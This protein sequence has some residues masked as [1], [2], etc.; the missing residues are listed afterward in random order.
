MA[1]G[2][3]RPVRR[4][5]IRENLDPV[6]VRRHARVGQP[7]KLSGRTSGRR[8]CASNGKHMGS[9]GK[10]VGPQEIQQQTHEWR[11]MQ[12]HVHRVVRYFPMC[13]TFFHYFCTISN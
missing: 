13:C 7:Q 3:G 4:G 6:E 9:W 12:C 5:Q 11:L 8:F 2:Y 10:G 1:S